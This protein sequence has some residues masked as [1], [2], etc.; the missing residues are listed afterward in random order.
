MDSG[1]DPPGRHLVKVLRRIVEWL[2]ETLDKIP[3]Y[4]D[5]RWYRYGDWGCRL[6][7]GKL[8]VDTSDPPS[9]GSSA[10]RTAV[11]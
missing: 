3:E 2:D 7:L 11:F 1:F 4:R 8:W 6:G 9:A 10:D 5:G